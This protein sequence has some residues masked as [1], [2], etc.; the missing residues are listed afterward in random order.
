MKCITKT[1]FDTR[2]L[3][4]TERLAL[5]EWSHRHDYLPDNFDVHKNS[6]QELSNL[7]QEQGESPRDI[8]NE[9]WENCSNGIN[10]IANYI[11]DPFN[12]I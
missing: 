9:Y 11:F 10:P 1:P 4:G 7:L 2:W 3:N 8:I 5:A 12:K 6:I